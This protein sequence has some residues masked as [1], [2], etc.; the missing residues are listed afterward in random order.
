M[1]S[2]LKYLL[3]PIYTNATVKLNV[4]EDSEYKQYVFSS[5]LPIIMQSCV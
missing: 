3:Q 4:T 2:L 5:L 1:F